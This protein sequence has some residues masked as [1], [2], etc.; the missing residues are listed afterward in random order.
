MVVG[1]YGGVGGLESRILVNHLRSLSSWVARQ[2]R[3]TE[4]TLRSEREREGNVG[5]MDDK[6]SVW[7][8]HEGKQNPTVCSKDRFVRRRAKSKVHDAWDVWCIHNGREMCRG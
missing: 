2:A 7:Q 5:Y 6:T 4:F 1:V 3:Y 8:K